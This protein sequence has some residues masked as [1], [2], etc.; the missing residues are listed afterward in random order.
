MYEWDLKLWAEPIFPAS[1]PIQ[2]QGRMPARLAR[3]PKRRQGDV[4]RREVGDVSLRGFQLSGL[5][6][7]PILINLGKSTYAVHSVGMPAVR[8]GSGLASR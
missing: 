4:K 6:T 3:H 7:I 5:G 1:E 2:L 8:Y